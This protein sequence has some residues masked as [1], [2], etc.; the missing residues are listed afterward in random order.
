MTDEFGIAMWIYE[1]KL[2][3]CLLFVVFGVLGLLISEV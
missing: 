3:A 2:E 1:N